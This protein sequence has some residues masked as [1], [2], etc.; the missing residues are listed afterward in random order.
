MVEA[1][2]GQP[3]SENGT[4]QQ[5]YMLSRVHALGTTPGPSRPAL[6]T[7]KKRVPLA[8]DPSRAPQVLAGLHSNLLYRRTFC[9]RLLQPRLHSRPFL[10]ENAEVNRTPYPARTGEQVPA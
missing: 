6:R 5:N 10:I 4:G 1:A 2:G 3:A 8:C 7:A 9:Q